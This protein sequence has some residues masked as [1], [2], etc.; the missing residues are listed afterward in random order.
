[1]AN[2]FSPPPDQSGVSQQLSY[3]F[4]NYGADP[5]GVANVVY[6][7]SDA[8]Y[9]KLKWQIMLNTGSVTLTPAPAILDPTDLPPATSQ[10]TLLYLSLKPLG[11]SDAVFKELEFTASGWSFQLFPAQQMVGMT[12]TQSINLGSG[13]AGMQV[14]GIANVQIGSAAQP[15]VDLN[16]QIYDAHF[17]SIY[18]SFK[19]ALQNAPDQHD[20]NLQDA[21]QVQ[22]STTSILNS[23]QAP[24]S[25]NTIQLVFAAGAKPAQIQA[26]KSSVFNVS[27]VYGPPG[28]QYGY[29]ALTTIDLAGNIAVSRL[30][31][32]DKW[33]I[34]PLAS[35]QNLSWNLLPPNGQP[36]L[37]DAGM[38]VGFVF[39]DIAT[40]YQPG[41]TAMLVAYQNIPGYQDGVFTIVLNKVGHATISDFTVTPNP[42]VAGADG[43][44]T[45]TVSWNATNATSLTLNQN[46]NSND[47]TGTSSFV[48]NLTTE[49]T[50][51][52][53]TALGPL[54]DRGNQALASATAAAL[55]VINSFTGGPTE[56]F[57]QEASHQATLAWAVET[58][59][60]GQVALTS[61]NSSFPGGSSLPSTY[62]MAPPLTGPQMLTLTPDGAANPLS[63]TR[64]LVV[65]AFAPSSSQLQV[66]SAP[67]G[68]AASPGAPFIAVSDAANN[69]VVI[70]DTVKYSQI[71]TVPVGAQPGPIAFSADGSI[72][73]VANTGG[74]SL[75][76]VSVNADSGLPVF[77][78]QSAV[79]LPAAPQSLLLDPSGERAY[80]VTDDGTGAG[81][82]LALKDS[83]GGYQQLSSV[84]VGHAPRG[85]AALASGSAI[86]VANSGDG[87]VSAVSVTASGALL[88]GVT[89]RGVG[90]QPMGLAVVDAAQ[91][92]L[93]C[94]A[95][96]NKVVAIDL[97]NP[98][99]GNRQ[100]V[101]VGNQPCALAIT[102]GGGY[103]F[104]GNKGDGTLSLLD[105]WGGVA[106]V[107][108]VGDAIAAG[109]N[110]VAV[111]VS[112][113]G[114]NVLSANS[115]NGSVS[116]VT[117]A[118]YQSAGDA[119][120]LGDHMTDAAVAPDKSF[121]FVWQNPLMGYT[122][123]P[124]IVAYNTLTGA[125]QGL[126]GTE[127][128]ISCVFN[129]RASLGVAYALLN[130][131]NQLCQ[132][133]TPGLMVTQLA[134]PLPSADCRALALGM[135]GDDSRLFVAYADKANMVWLMVL[136]RTDSGW[137][138]PQMLQLY[139]ASARPGL[140]LVAPAFD[141][142]T[143]V[144]VDPTSSTIRFCHNASGSYVFDSATVTAQSTARGIALLPDGS[145]AYVLNSGGMEH[146]LTVIDM[147]TLSGKVVSIPQNYVA[148]TGIV[149][150]PDGRR[151]YA[152]DA[153]AGALR[154][155]DPAS[156]RI[157]QTISLTSGSGQTVQN[158]V[159]VAM[160]CDASA[161]YVINNSSN[162]MSV[163][164]QIQMQ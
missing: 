77:A 138:T 10:G 122:S 124:G 111:S 75:T 160:A 155:L 145:A 92:L 151:L 90:T 81:T 147:T 4:V 50:S 68:V 86:Y 126:L 88:P 82:L 42:T 152:C 163:V 11:L 93:V 52:S 1:M 109:A 46:W 143:V 110:P 128:V 55:P 22:L 72:M 97:R 140:V 30:A 116:V 66:G 144:I 156:L 58:V 118:T 34:V 119:V 20:G 120:V 8:S 40:Q 123:T 102:P 105:C 2:P 29:G 28:D 161:L 37:G 69:Q 79:P 19:V 73:M 84:A 104:V 43:T 121:V 65:S 142:Q 100:S 54:S 32:A 36:I 5:G 47:V 60:S 62:T 85:L 76:P 61:T 17:A 16:T 51:F 89:V 98:N 53:L 157:L 91:V 7:T 71:T 14:I 26:G 127:Q 103:A 24:V 41:P 107:K 159:A 129:P 15:T 6:L 148:L 25:P 9:N 117:L 94:C 70:L 18:G 154:V 139:Q 3:Q 64:K 113:D 96:D 38:T 33:Q 108:V 21:I 49:S 31:N 67:S 23:Y 44:A 164:E 39:D 133:Q 99:T 135:G 59:G 131:G 112:P 125:Q 87:T 57:C 115:V 137:G 106:N 134:L 45:V 162:N 132:I 83:G 13:A 78:P 74:N 48:A 101:A 153:N 146:D 141:G 130:E 12:P 114:L 150:A 158:P 56:I 27:F 63:L 35:A 80:V 95:G 149:S 136:P